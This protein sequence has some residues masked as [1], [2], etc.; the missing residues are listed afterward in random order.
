MN[1][2][3]NWTEARPRF[4][5]MTLEGISTE[6]MAEFKEQGESCVMDLW[7]D[8]IREEI[9]M[10]YKFPVFRGVNDYHVTVYDHES[11]GTNLKLVIALEEIN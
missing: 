1:I 8:Q 6:D 9:Y 3:C 10:G 7:G 4:I 2:K 5:D 11:A